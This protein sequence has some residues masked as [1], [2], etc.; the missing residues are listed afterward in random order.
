MSQ[1]IV[2][3][4]KTSHLIAEVVGFLNYQQYTLYCNH[5]NFEALQAEIDENQLKP[6]TSITMICTEDSFT[7][8][9]Q[10]V[11]NWL[12]AQNLNIEL[13]FHK[14]NQ[15]TDI[16]SQNDARMMR[17][18]I[19]SIV[20]KV[21]KMG[22]T[23]DLYLCLSSG[24]KTMSSDIQQAAYLFGC[25]AMIHILAEGI[26][27]FDLTAN[28]KNIE[29]AVINKINP[30]LYQKD[31]PAGKLAELMEDNE[32]K[33][34]KA[35]ITD[36]IYS[37][38]DEDTSFLDLV[39]KLQTQQDNLTINYYNKLRYSE[40]A[41]NFQILHLLNPDKINE[42]KKKYINGIDNSKQDLRWLYNLPKTD[43]HCHLGGFADT[44]GLIKIATANAKYLGNSLKEKELERRIIAFI[45]KKN[46][47][48]LR[49]TW[50]AIN[51]QENKLRCLDSSLYLLC[52]ENNE[53][54]LEQVI[55]GD[56][57]QEENFIAIGLNSYEEIGDFQGSTILQTEEALREICKQLKDDAKKN[58]L[59]YKELRCSPCNY[60]NNLKAN[61]VVEILYD[62]LK[63]AECIFRLIIIGSRHK[64]PKILK[65]HINLC[66]ELK[67]Q[68][69]KISDFICGFDLAGT[70]EQ[71]MQ[72]TL[73]LR[74]TI[75]P[76]LENCLRI[77]IH[78]GETTSVQN[79][80]NAVYN[81]NAD[82]IGHGLYL[83]DDENLM[84][85]LKDKRTAIELCP[86]SNFQINRYRD[87]SI[88]ST[89]KM[90][91]YPLRQYLQKGIKVCICSDDPG[92][93][94]TDISKEYW[95]AA[96]MTEGGLSKWEILTLIRNGFVSSF[97]SKEQ[98]QELIK[99]AEQKIM[100]LV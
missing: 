29:P 94:R 85:K 14:L 75:L 97:Q 53:N 95:K 99:K 54:L 40:P 26:V 7:T 50:K 28:P 31:I 11:E 58:N 56:M 72:E 91:I 13:Q 47:N 6:V 63:D 51:M 36:N 84:E 78:S 96:K 18:L 70:E 41:S 79:M 17:N 8:S 77:T 38:N 67:E 71:E 22:N 42:L 55:W 39:E 2:S 21:Y 44:K 10:E 68:S 25:K 12:T 87:Y 60:T 62:E 16:L 1:L 88:N 81:L 15:L 69:G 19:Y 33:L 27:E 43:L 20:Y 52:F 73:S 32:V 74:E 65:E 61:E 45:Q 35:E 46:L 5:K 24:R 98:K 82:R 37:Y 93:S 48:E 23:Q 90:S 59:L 30:V 64:S 83:Q 57:L 92:I 4:G 100:Q 80:W 76:L 89:S 49:A 9:K 34:P 66:K 86:S 3:M